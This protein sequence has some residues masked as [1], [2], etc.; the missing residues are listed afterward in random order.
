MS[1]DIELH[2]PVDKTIIKFDTP[3]QMKGGTY[4]FG[5]TTEAWL[6]ITWN[7][8]KHYSMLFGKEGIRTIYGMTGADSIPLLEKA[9]SQLGNDVHPDYWKPTEG[10]AKRPL[11]QLAA[12]AKMRPDGI[13]NGD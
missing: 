1:Y 8:G 9:A 3:I 6:N 5:G 10:N 13:W 12:M 2:D 7:Y 11:L 4:E